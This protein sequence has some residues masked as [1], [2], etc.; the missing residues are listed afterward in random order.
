MTF[1]AAGLYALTGPLSSEIIR[2]YGSWVPLAHQRSLILFASAV[3]AILLHLRSS[4][5]F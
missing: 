5:R 1:I 4:W 2:L 3:H